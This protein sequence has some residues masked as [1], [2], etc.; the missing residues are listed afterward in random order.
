M[1]PTYPGGILSSLCLSEAGGTI[2]S[3][4]RE[5]DLGPFRFAFSEYEFAFSYQKGNPTVCYQIWLGK[6]PEEEL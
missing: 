5:N 2:S 4:D 3:A 6:S 1:R